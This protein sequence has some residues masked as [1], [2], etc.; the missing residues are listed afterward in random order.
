MEKQA[1]DVL[2]AQASQRD[3]SLLHGAQAGRRIKEENK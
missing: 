1:F 2:D 3:H